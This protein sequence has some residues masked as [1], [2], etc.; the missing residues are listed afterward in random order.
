MR[1]KMEIILNLTIFILALITAILRFLEGVVLFPMI[2]FLLAVA[3][4]AAVILRLK[5]KKKKENEP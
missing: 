3:N 5:Q 1:S 2:L 4:G